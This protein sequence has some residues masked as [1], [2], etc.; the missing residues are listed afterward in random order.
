MWPFHTS[1]VSVIPTSNSCLT[2][3]HDHISFR[4]QAQVSALDM[5]LPVTA[6]LPA[7]Q[8]LSPSQV[9]LHLRG[10]IFLLPLPLLHPGQ[11]P[12]GC[13][14]S[15]S[16]PSGSPGLHA[17][18]WASCSS[19]VTAL[20]PH[21]VCLCFPLCPSKDTGYSTLVPTMGSC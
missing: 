3:L 4:C 2:A 18:S 9:A 7:L 11:L 13:K 15:R 8:S 12:L 20:S 17:G 19:K 14:S 5:S 1:L 6:P 10:G 16:A 21:A